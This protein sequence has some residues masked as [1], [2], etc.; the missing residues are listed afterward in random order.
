MLKVQ[1]TGK[2]N[3]EE[4]NTLQSKFSHLEKEHAEEQD[5]SRHLMQEK[6]AAIEKMKRIVE[7]LDGTQNILEAG[8]SDAWNSLDKMKEENALV[9]GRAMCTV[10]N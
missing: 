6:M 5:V 2:E 9:Y 1:Q 8:L 3:I 7:E 4:S 10:A